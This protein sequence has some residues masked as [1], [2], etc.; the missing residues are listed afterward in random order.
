MAVTN[1]QLFAELEADLKAAHFPGSIWEQDS[2]I[3]VSTAC[4][5][6]ISVNDRMFPTRCEK[7]NRHHFVL[8]KGD[9]G[10]LR[11]TAKIGGQVQTLDLENVAH[12]T[13][14]VSCNALEPVPAFG[15]PEF[16]N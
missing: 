11:F 6:T 9:D 15:T 14:F 13:R 2:S 8:S 12:L 16:W 10:R 1:D 3:R 7:S 4:P 5:G